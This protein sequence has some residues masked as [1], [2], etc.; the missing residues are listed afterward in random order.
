MHDRHF[1]LQ[2]E[3][4]FPIFWYKNLMKIFPKELE[5]IVEFYKY[6]FSKNISKSLSKNWQKFSKRKKKLI[7]RMSKWGCASSIWVR[8]YRD[9]GLAPVWGFLLVWYILRISNQDP[10]D[11]PEIWGPGQLLPSSSVYREQQ[12]QASSSREIALRCMHSGRGLEKRAPPAA[13]AA[14]DL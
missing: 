4:S 2:T 10:K 11:V 6:V 14:V 9:L 1:G 5:K 7:I 8:G 13:A 12:R 3:F